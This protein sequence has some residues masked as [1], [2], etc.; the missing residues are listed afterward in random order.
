MPTMKSK[1]KIK[2]IQNLDV[3]V[4]I[5]I[6]VCLST[7]KGMTLPQCT[8]GTA[9]RLLLVLGVAYVDLTDGVEQQ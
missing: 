7:N 3:T 6:D 1:L 8:V 2:G 9:Q 5:G 4:R